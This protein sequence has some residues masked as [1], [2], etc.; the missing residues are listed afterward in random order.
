M[1]VKTDCDGPQPDIPQAWYALQGLRMR[2][3]ST[4][5]GQKLKSAGEMTEPQSQ[6]PMFEINSTR[7]SRRHTLLRYLPTGNKSQTSFDGGMYHNDAR[8]VGSERNGHPEGSGCSKDG[9]EAIFT[10]DMLVKALNGNGHVPSLSFCLLPFQMGWI[11]RN[12]S[13]RADVDPRGE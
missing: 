4:P 5:L 13:W 2:H 11:M 9:G 8:L 12:Q 3:V 1:Q 7:D 10:H 6:P